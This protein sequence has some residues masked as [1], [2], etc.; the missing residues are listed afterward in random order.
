MILSLFDA[1][2]K[3]D[4]EAELS[5]SLEQNPGNIILLAG[6]AY[7]YAARGDGGRAVELAQKAMRQEPR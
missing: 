2:K 6:A 5:K 3:A 4:A 7:W 1:G